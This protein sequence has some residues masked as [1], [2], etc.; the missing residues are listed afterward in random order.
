MSAR[1]SDTELRVPFAAMEGVVVDVVGAWEVDVEVA[2]GWLVDVDGSGGLD[3][4]LGTPTGGRADAMTATLTEGA[5]CGG[6]VLAVVTVGADLRVVPVVGGSTV[7]GVTSTVVR[8][9]TQRGM[10]AVQ[11]PLPA[12][13]FMVGVGTTRWACEPTV[14]CTGPNAAY[15]AAGM[16]KTLSAM[17]DATARREGRIQRYRPTGVAP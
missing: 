11:C 2:G 8:V 14:A 15:A 5:G 1:I 3:V 9:V 13:R 16:A 4:G 7:C 10:T 6:W 12:A 17:A